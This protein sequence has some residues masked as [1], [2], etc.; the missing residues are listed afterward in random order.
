[1]N[2]ETR[3]LQ[4]GKAAVA[5]FDRRGWEKNSEVSRRLFPAREAHIC[6]RKVEAPNQSDNFYNIGSLL[7]GKKLSPIFQFTIPDT[8]SVRDAFNSFFSFAVT[9]CVIFN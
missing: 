4:L 7:K 2:V 1:M 6:C 3:R 5:G 9:E 8:I